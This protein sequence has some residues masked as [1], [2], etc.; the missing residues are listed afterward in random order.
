MTVD[1]KYEPALMLAKIS[2]AERDVVHEVE[3]AAFF[4]YN[5]NKKDRLYR[6]AHISILRSDIAAIGIKLFKFE[7]LDQNLSNEI[8]THSKATKLYYINLHRKLKSL[9]EN[10]KILKGLRIQ[11]ENILRLLEMANPDGDS[12]LSKK[13][14]DYREEVLNLS[15]DYAKIEMILSRSNNFEIHLP[16]SFAPDPGSTLILNVA[17]YLGLLCSIFKDKLEQNE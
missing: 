7:N 3:R 11:L 13:F 17:L 1:S 6:E 14:N 16:K 12:L 8:F 2:Q 5:Y 15:G 10:L 9:R 4:I